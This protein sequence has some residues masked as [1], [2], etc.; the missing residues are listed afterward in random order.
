MWLALDR[1]EKRRGEAMDHQRLAKD[2]GIG[3]ATLHRILYGDREPPAMAIIGF[4]RL[5]GVK[6][7]LWAQP[8]KNNFVP[9]AA[10]DAA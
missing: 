7:K 2:V 6:C 9:P 5:F 3:K 10:R 8:S 1:W 4:E